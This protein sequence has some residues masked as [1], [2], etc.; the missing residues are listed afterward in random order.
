M[1]QRV[2]TSWQLI[3]AS[4]AILRSDEGLIVYPIVST[5]ALVIVTAAF[6]VPLWT[7]GAM[8]QIPRLTTNGVNR[9]TV[10]WVI[11]LFLFYIIQYFIIFFA[12]SA[13]I[14]AVMLRLRGGRGS[15]SDGF[16]VALQHVSQI[17]GYAVIS[18]T[19]GMVLRAIAERGA[20]GRIFATITNLGW[21]VT[22]YLVVPVLV[23]EDV[24]PV[25][26]IKRSGSLLKR[27][28]GEQIVGNVGVSAVFGLIMLP[29]MVIGVA[30]AGTAVVYGAPLLALGVIV[31][32]VV[33]ILILSVISS[34]LRGIYQAV[35]YQ[36]AATGQ[37]DGRFDA[38]LVRS[39]FRP[40]RGRF[41]Y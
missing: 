4:T 7:S 11:L 6:A 5:L 25:E 12:N 2:A 17:F 18:A 39:A 22:T 10:A 31:L 37:V 14:G 19:V 8:I 9:L 23:M 21:N 20:I 35:V 34:A 33:A 41:I 40:K 30:L 24:G 3:K 1:F 16:D 28:W 29:I 38:D 13:L 27:T 36:Y 26:A 32:M 15:V